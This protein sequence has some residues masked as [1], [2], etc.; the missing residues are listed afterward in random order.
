MFGQMKLSV[1]SS[2]FF[3]NANLASTMRM[4]NMLERFKDSKTSV[5]FM[6]KFMHDPWLKSLKNVTS[7]TV[8]SYLI[9]C[10]RAKLA[11][12]RLYKG[13]TM[14]LLEIAKFAANLWDSR[15]SI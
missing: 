8:L 7:R 4:Q 13:T 3:G 2:S 12:H 10:K 1:G 6:V 15:G 14:R 9:I 5:P 11:S